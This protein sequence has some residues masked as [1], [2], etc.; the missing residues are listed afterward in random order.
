MILI[1]E[2]L[3][4]EKVIFYL[5]DQLIFLIDESLFKIIL[6]FYILEEQLD[7]TIW[8]SVYTLLF[9]WGDTSIRLSISSV[10]SLVIYLH[11]QTSTL[12]MDDS[13]WLSELNL[14]VYEINHQ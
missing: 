8:D 11:I 10:L 2:R 5:L 4:W 14:F 1:I 9:F 12:S 13:D 6:V 3:D 7:H